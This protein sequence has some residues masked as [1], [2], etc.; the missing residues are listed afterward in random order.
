SH[1]GRGALKMSPLPL[2]G[3]VAPKARVRVAHQET[4]PPSPLPLAGEVAPKARV[5]VAHQETRQQV[6]LLP[7]QH[8]AASTHEPPAGTSSTTPKAK[9]PSG[10]PTTSATSTAP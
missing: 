9:P 7:N 6:K 3:E 4:R 2:A 5:R 10:K 1:K 8:A